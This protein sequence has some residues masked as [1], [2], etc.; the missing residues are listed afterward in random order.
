MSIAQSE[1][2]RS[3]VKQRDARIQFKLTDI[4]VENYQKQTKI[5]IPLLGSNA[6][7]LR[8]YVVALPTES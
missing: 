6:G 2:Y 1:H 3:F 5:R 7:N 8:S 4:Y